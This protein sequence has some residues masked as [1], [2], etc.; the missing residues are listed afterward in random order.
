MDNRITFLETPQYDY[1]HRTAINAS[2]ADVTIAFAVD[3]TTA[4]EK[5]T[6]RL[7]RQSGN[8]YVSINANVREVSAERIKILRARLFQDQ[9]RTLNIAGNSLHTLRGRMSQADCDEF[10]L[11]FL[12]GA[13][14]QTRYPFLY[15]ESIRS[16]GQTGF[17]EAGLKAAMRLQ[18]PAICLAPKGWRFRGADGVDRCDEIAFKSRFDI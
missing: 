3:F 8:R 14:D 6:K 15:I 13:L 17:D 5:L 9:C 16:G 18:I 4:G 1:Q 12:G 2:G 7:V 10:V 11:D